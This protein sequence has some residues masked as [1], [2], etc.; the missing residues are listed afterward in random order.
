MKLVF[1][2]II[3][4]K[5]YSSWSL[6]PWIAMK[7]F[8]LDFHEIYIP[9]G[10]PP[11]RAENL[12]YSPSGKVPV[13][14]V[15]QGDTNVVTVWDSLAICEYLA[16]EIPT[17]WPKDKIARALARSISNE[18]HSG[19]N[20]L[21]QNMPMDCKN[22]NIGKGMALGVRKD[23]ERITEI[24][25]DCRQNYGQGGPYLFGQFTIADAMYAP[26][27]LRFITYGV[28]LDQVSKDYVEAII[29]L[30]HLNE[31]IKS[32]KMEKNHRPEYDF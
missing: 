26:V 19:F 29:S 10:T 6:R 2:L 32:A 16:E 15:M 23:I 4:D 14:Q 25:K 7:Q 28:E 3:G 1:N 18:M 13:L 20:A 21:R 27:V 12:K 31:W 11:T 9:T 24:W 22:T 30:P 17:M 5:N 8:G